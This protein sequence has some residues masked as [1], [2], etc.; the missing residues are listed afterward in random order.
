VE[1]NLHTTFS[2]PNP[3]SESVLRC[4]KILLSFLMRF[5]CHFW[6]NQQQQQ[7]LP[8]FQSILE[9]HLFRQLLPAPFRLEIENTTEKSSISSEPHSHKP[10]VPILVFLSQ[11]D[12]LWNKI[13]WQLSVHFRHPW[14]IKNWLYKT[15]YNSY[16]VEDKQTKLGVWTD[17]GW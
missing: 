16:T 9:G 8:Q 15:S 10:F 11:I 6:P 4:S 12:R 2:F 3:L 5:D 1:Q 17:V 14:R 13:I 7:C